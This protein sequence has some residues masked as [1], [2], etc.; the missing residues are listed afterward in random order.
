[1][2]PISILVVDDHPLFR[3]ALCMAIESVDDMCVI[4]EAVNGEQAVSMAVELRP[5]LILMDL[6][7]PLKNGLDATREIME[8][9]PDM[10]VLMLTSSS[11]DQKVIEALQAG[12]SGYLIKDTARQQLLDGIRL[13]ASGEVF[14]P[15]QVA[16]KLARGIQTGIKKP[17][18]QK[19]SAEKLTQREEQVLELL[20]EGLSNRAIAE[21]LCIS[22]STARVHVYNI[23]GKLD[24]DNRSQAI[25]YA[26]RRNDARAK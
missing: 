7:L 12:A 9:I 21:A 3:E 4:G 18:G 16:S 19:K 15:V 10:R 25:V 22:E 13:V 17:M 2:K 8:Q 6:Y 11:E 1:M 23:L 26:L 24:L 14:L 20:G 5:D